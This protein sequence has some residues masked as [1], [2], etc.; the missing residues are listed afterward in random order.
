MP[1][2]PH[3]FFDFR[4][5]K[6]PTQYPAAVTVHWPTGPVHCCP[7]HGDALH[8]AHVHEFECKNEGEAVEEMYVDKLRLRIYK[9]KDDQIQRYND[10]PGKLPKD[11][12]DQLRFIEGQII[13]QIEAL[14][15]VLTQLKAG[16]PAS[17]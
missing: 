9:R 2:N 17:S 1:T 7:K 3:P 11:E 6:K 5:D 8:D 14:E 4:M 10:L 12:G 16:A 13:G 15:W